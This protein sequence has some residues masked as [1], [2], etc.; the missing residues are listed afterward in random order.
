MPDRV[1][2]RQPSM[3]SDDDLVFIDADI[4]SYLAAGCSADRAWLCLVSLPH[5]L[6]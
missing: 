2:G 6:P 3:L 5:A 1:A 4:N